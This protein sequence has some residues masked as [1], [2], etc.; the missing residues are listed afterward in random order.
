MPGQD[1]PNVLDVV[2]FGFSFDLCPRLWLWQIVTVKQSCTRTLPFFTSSLFYLLFVLTD[3]S[4]YILTVTTFTLEIQDQNLIPLRMECDSRPGPWEWEGYFL[5]PEAMSE[6]GN[7][8]TQ[9]RTLKDKSSFSPPCA[10]HPWLP[11]FVP[12]L[13]AG[14]K[15]SWIYYRKLKKLEFLFSYVKMQIFEMNV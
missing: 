1:E 14:C 15:R 8:T 4:L 12:E 6:R 7:K 13:D 3:T 5:L 9:C 10:W 2:C 11:N